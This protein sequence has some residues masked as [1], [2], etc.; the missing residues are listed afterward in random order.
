M[1]LGSLLSVG[2]SVAR[3]R[4]LGGH[5]GRHCS[6]EGDCEHDAR[7]GRT[8]W[9]SMGAGR[10]SLA[11]RE[12]RVPPEAGGV[13]S[14]RVS[15]ARRHENRH[16]TVDGAVAM[17]RAERV[18]PLPQPGYASASAAATRRGVMDRVQNEA[19]AGV[20]A[21]ADAGLTAGY[22]LG[23]FFDEMFEA[24]ASPRAALPRSCTRASPR[25]RRRRSRSAA[26]S[27]R[28]SSSRRA[29]ASRS[30][31]TSEGIERI[32]PF[33]LVPRIVPADEWA[34]IE[35]GLDQRMRALNLF[36]ERRLPRP[37]DPRGGRRPARARVRRGTSAAR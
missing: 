12:G 4:E 8:P 15:G 22:D 25:S 33:D 2:R 31:A 20:A 18:V 13:P 14:G 9:P 17:E 6:D 30:T 10:K 1:D 21:G 11:G 32:L 23:G 28:R 36:L 26:A 37:A 3:V 35:R 34:P 19:P 16:G 29:S 5:E 24:P 7:D 27:P